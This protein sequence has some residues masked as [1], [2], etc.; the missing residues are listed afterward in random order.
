MVPGEP[1]CC[2]DAV[3]TRKPDV[4]QHHVRAELVDQG[5]CDLTGV[6]VTDHLYVGVRLEYLASAVAMQGMVVDHD[7]SYH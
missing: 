5:E 3:H 2:L 6:S 1:T 7:H 4:H